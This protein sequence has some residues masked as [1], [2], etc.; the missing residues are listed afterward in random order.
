MHA[1]RPFLHPTAKDD[2]RFFKRNPSRILRLRKY[3]KGELGFDANIEL[4]RADGFGEVVS[5]DSIIVRQYP[6]F[7]ERVPFAL[8]ATLIRN[9]D[10]SIVA[11]LLRNGIDPLTMRQWGLVS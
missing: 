9:T 4:F 8:G 2:I 3:V 1:R 5:V 10:E 11:F 6:H 7:R